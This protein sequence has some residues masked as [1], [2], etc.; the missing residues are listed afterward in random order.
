MRH[1]LLIINFKSLLIFLYL[2]NY[3]KL[4]ALLIAL[5]LNFSMFHVIQHLHGNAVCLPALLVMLAFA[6]IISLSFYFFFYKIFI[7][8]RPPSHSA[9]P[10]RM[11]LYGDFLHFVSKNCNY[12]SSGD[13]NS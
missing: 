9:L 1:V 13:E 10:D 6:F 3:M 8:F 12:P 5:D 11:K 7:S 2:E 4:L